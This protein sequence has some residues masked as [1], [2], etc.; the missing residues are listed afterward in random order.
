MIETKGHYLDK[1][2][3]KYCNSHRGCDSCKLYRSCEGNCVK[4]FKVVAKFVI[5]EMIKEETENNASK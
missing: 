1:L 3:T 2:F 4:M 5:K